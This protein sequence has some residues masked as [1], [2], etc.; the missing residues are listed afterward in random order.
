MAPHNTSSKPFYIS[1]AIL[2]LLLLSIGFIAYISVTD[3]KISSIFTKTDQGEQFL[4]DTNPQGVSN[5]PVK[6][7]SSWILM[8]IAGFGV[9][10]I[11][12]ILFAA[13]KTKKMQLTTREIKEIIFLCE[14]PMYLGLLGSLLGVCLTQFMT[15]TLSAPL[16]YITTITGI[17]LHLFAKFTII[18]PLPGISTHNTSEEV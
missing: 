14:T 13:S 17:L 12:P 15:G 16:A 5:N 11:I 3:E 2:I 10:Q 8:L 7:I 4:I 9:L 1:L 6:D 18:V